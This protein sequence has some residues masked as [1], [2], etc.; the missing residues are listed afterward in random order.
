[1][2]T[3]FEVEVLAA[4]QQLLAWCV[5]QPP[6]G[7][8]ALP[9]DLCQPDL[10]L[11]VQYTDEVWEEAEGLLEW[12]EAYEE[13][14]ARAAT[15]NL[16]DSLVEKLGNAHFLLC[17][18]LREVVEGL[19]AAAAGGAQAAKALE[20]AALQARFLQGQRGAVQ[21]NGGMERFLLP[22][23]QGLE[24]EAEALERLTAFYRRGQWQAVVQAAEAFSPALEKWRAQHPGL[25]P[26]WQAVVAP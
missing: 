10:G 25:P 12:V 22:Y 15:T 21:G 20:A 9:Q 24:T 11:L 13:Y 18:Q 3:D 14:L 8:L 1:M 23:L 17:E 26:A 2:P 16:L 19:A 4:C 7:P 6:E 5:Q